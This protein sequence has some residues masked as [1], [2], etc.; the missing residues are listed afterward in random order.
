MSSAV[1]SLLIKTEFHSLK[2]LAGEV[3]SHSCIEATPQSYFHWCWREASL[4]GN[5]KAAL[6]L[7]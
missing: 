1:G 3:C 6:M 2:L 7:P 4:Y 5:L